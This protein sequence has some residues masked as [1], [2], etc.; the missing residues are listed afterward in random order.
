M[1]FVQETANWTALVND[2]DTA[3]INGVT[4]GNALLVCILGTTSGSRTFALSSD[5]DGA[6]D[7]EIDDDPATS[8]I[9]GIYALFNASAGNHTITF[10]WTAGLTA[11]VKIIEVS[12][13]DALATPIWRQYSEPTNTNSH[14]MVDPVDLMTTTEAAF[15]FGAA[16]LNSTTG[17]Q[18]ALGSYTA[19]STDN[20]QRYAQYKEEAGAVSNEDGAWQGSGTARTGNSTLVA[21]PLAATAVTSRPNA[22]VAAGSWTPSG[23]ASLHAAVNDVSNTTFIRS[24]SGEASDACDLGF[25][26]MTGPPEPGA[27]S[28]SITYRSTP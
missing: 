21:F 25:P 14:V 4:A 7:W 18:T 26:T 28:F 17:A 23:A 5:L 13:L 12:G 8:R 6:F 1:P 3:V 27:V 24:S 16:T 15:F 20:N 22:T 10:T 2:G 19:L 11:Q 9:S